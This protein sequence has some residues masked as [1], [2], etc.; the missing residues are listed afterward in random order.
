[1]RK[2][3]LIML[4][5]TIFL[6]VYIAGKARIYHGLNS[7]IAWDFGGIEILPMPV[8]FLC[9]GDWNQNTMRFEW[10]NPIAKWYPELVTD[11]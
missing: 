9:A 2:I 8:I 4:I 3:N 11:C 1:M 6:S 5:I 7:G 10:E